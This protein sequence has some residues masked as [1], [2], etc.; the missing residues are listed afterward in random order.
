MSCLINL[1]VVFPIYLIL[2]CFFVGYLMVMGAIYFVQLLIYGISFILTLIIELITKKKQHSHFKKPTVTIHN[3]VLPKKPQ[4]QRRNHKKVI[5]T[6][7]EEKE[8][9]NE[10]KLW[11]LSESDKKL[12]KQERMSPADFVEA[13][14]RNDDVLD[15]DEF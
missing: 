5:D 8:F 12:A 2:G 11:G 9:E 3:F 4:S 1:L 7:Y 14:E 15:T 13:E 6:T 10:A